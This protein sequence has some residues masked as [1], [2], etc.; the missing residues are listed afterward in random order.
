MSLEIISHL[1]LLRGSC[2]S[3]S[4]A[5]NGLTTFGPIGPSG[6]RRAGPST[7][8][9]AV[10]TFHKLIISAS[11]SLVVVA[12]ATASVAITLAPREID[13]GDIDN[14]FYSKIEFAI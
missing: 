5:P 12:P 10:F 14:M 9:S 1:L 13:N 4:I 2:F 3:F 7:T 8:I 6:D 11:T